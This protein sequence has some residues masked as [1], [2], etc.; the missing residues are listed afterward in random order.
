MTAVRVDTASRFIPVLPHVVYQAFVMPG[1]M[2]RWLPPDTMVGEMLHFDFREGGSYRMRLIYTDPTRASGKTTDR[3]DEVEVRLTRIEENRMIAQD[4]VF[5]SED[6]A[7][8]GVMHMVWFFVPDGLGTLVTIRAE[9][10][11][12]GIRT[13]DH[14]AGMTSSLTQLAAYVVR[15]QEDSDLTASQ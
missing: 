13:E 2:E 8:A 6:P 5:Q 12:P 11:P 14:V 10:V 15:S 1:A 7:F 9:N 4:I 3:V